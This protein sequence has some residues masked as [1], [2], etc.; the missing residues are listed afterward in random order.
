VQALKELSESKAETRVGDRRSR[1]YQENAEH[2]LQKKICGTTGGRA[3][4]KTQDP[5]KRSRDSETSPSEKLLKKGK[6]A[7]DRRKPN[8]PGGK[9]GLLSKP[10]KTKKAR[11]RTRSSPRRDEKKDFV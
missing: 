2:Q 4:R 3:K 6:P 5:V 7:K 1:S 11:T 10:T 8:L 9:T